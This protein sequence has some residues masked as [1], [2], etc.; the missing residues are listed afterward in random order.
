MRVLDVGC[1]NGFLLGHFLKK[2]CTVVGI[3]LS[4]QGVALARRTYPKGRFELL[5]ADDK[6]LDVLGEAP[7]DIVISTEVIEHLYAPRDFGRGCETCRS[8]RV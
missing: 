2:G 1:G 6:I 3:D 8:L 4:E 5:S 7:F